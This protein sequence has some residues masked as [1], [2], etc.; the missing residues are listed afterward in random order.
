MAK[1][2]SPQ[3]VQDFT[4]LVVLFNEEF[5]GEI[6]DHGFRIIRK[7]EK[8]QPEGWLARAVA[9]GNAPIC[10]HGGSYAAVSDNLGLQDCRGVANQL[11]P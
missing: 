9:L 7:I 10:E 3:I 2:F 4:Q 6:S 11:V 1:E 5:F 8:P